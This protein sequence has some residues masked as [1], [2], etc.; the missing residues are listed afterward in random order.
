MTAETTKPALMPLAD[1]DA[2]CE[3]VSNWGRWGADDQ[4]GTLNY[5]TA[6]RR[7][8]ARDQ[9]RDGQLVSCAND[10]SGAG[11]VDDPR[12]PLHVPFWSRMGDLSVAG[13]ALTITPHGWTITHLDSLSHVIWRGKMYNGVDVSPYR[14]ADQ[15]INSIMS[16]KDGVIGRG[17]LIDL[18]A[19]MGRDYLDP[20]D[21]GHLSDVE[22][23]L[24]RQKC[25]ILPGDIVY[26]RTG[27]FGRELT[28]GPAPTSAGLAGVS[29]DCVDWAHEK[30]ISLFV[31]DGG[32]DPQP[33]EVEG[34]RIPWH[35][36]T[37]VQMGAMLID[38]ANL[39][40]LAAACEQKGRWTFMTTLAPLRVVAG[41]A[42]PIN[43]IAMF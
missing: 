21:I 5:L 19:A 1:F 22:K 40:A 3:R 42:S 39:E 6:E 23:A 20:G 18:P 8:A 25:E 38:N 27:R 34:V 43:P 7:A 15:S 13:E 12:P 36:L 24:E 11:R 41:N 2:L 28:H 37:L 31:C 17:V 29:V 9:I 14:S 10:I 30:Q 16:A 4:A 26:F 33:S 35:I 32:M